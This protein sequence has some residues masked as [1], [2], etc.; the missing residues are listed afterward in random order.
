M[1]PAGKGMYWPPLIVADT[2]ELVMSEAWASG[3]FPVGR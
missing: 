1:E 2:C 3:D